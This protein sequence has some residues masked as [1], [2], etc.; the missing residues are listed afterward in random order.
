MSA[1]PVVF[2][3]VSFAGL[4]TAEEEDVPVVPVVLPDVPVPVPVVLVTF[5]SGR[6]FPSFTTTGETVSLPDAAV[7]AEAV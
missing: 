1:V 4:A 5:F 2:A 6:V 3:E 7:S